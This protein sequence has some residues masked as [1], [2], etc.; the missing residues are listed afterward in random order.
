MRAWIGLSAAALVLCAA[1]AHANPPVEAFGKLP[2]ME[3]PQIAPDG[4]HFSVIQSYN[5]R[6]AVVI[7]TANATPDQ[8]PVVIAPADW[9]IG[10][11]QWLKN[12]RLAVFIKV[13]RAI[14]DDTRLVHTWYRAVSVDFN[15]AKDVMLLSDLPDINVN[16]DAAYIV[17]R[18]VDDP[19]DIFMSLLEYVDL[20]SP[21]EEATDTKTGRAERNFYRPELFRVDAHTGKHSRVLAG[22]YDTQRWFMDGHGR[23]LARLDQT[24]APLHDR[25]LAL[26]GT[27]WR[28]VADYDASGD[29]GAGVEGVTEDGTALVSTAR[30]AK[31]MGV[32]V[33]LDLKT[34]AYSKLFSNPKYDVDEGVLDPWTDRVIGAAYVDD[35]PEIQYFDPKMEA[36]QKGL[37]AAFPNVS[38]T[39]LSWN[40]AKDEIF[41]QIDSPKHPMEYYFLDRTTHAATRIGSAYPDLQESDLGEM[42]PYPYKARDGLDIPAYLTL[43]P[44]KTAKNLPVVVMPHGGP[45]ARDSIG[46]DWM[47]QFFANRGYAVLQPN[48]RGSSGYGQAFTDAGLHQWGLKMQDDLTDGVKALVAGGIADPKRVCIVGGSYGGYAALA[49]AALTPDVYACAVSFAGISDLPKMLKE[50]R[51][52]Y[53]KDSQAVSFWI[54][55]IGSSFDDS[56]QLRATSPARQADKIKCPVLL[57]H[58]E[59]DTT[60]PIEQSEIMAGAMKSAGKQVEFIRF[61]GEDHHFNL[62]DTRIRFL[63][64]T[65][66]FLEKNIGK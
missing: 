19:N 61:P 9:I 48:Y 15:G 21:S 13:N 10:G 16:I 4:K 39:A 6:R 50:E 43:P 35:K 57:M 33:R 40:T 52:R 37:E 45:D 63:K 12:D 66:A 42:K 59:G 20:R 55:R 54:S 17:D 58:G 53:G 28:T 60:V 22:S 11:A 38:V 29:N 49:G 51:A 23:L 56:E 46:F 26:D 14:D 47:A 2:D 18:D 34:A 62:A 36:L 24:Q 8:K 7:Y 5:G 3:S 64:E 31:G 32:L 27:S 25:V 30:D 1:A 65:A 41:V 44:G